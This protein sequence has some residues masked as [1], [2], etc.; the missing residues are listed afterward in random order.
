MSMYRI[1]RRKSV[2]ILSLWVSVFG[3]G[4]S[5]SRNYEEFAVLRFLNG[6][7]C[8]ALMQALA[9]WGWYLLFK[10]I[11]FQ[12]LS[13][14]KLTFLKTIGVEAIASNV[15]VKFIFV[16]YCF[17]SLGNLL[18]GLLAYLVRDWVTLQLYL[19]S[20]MTV[21]VTYFL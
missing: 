6:M 2:L 10:V 18:T 12:P 20:P 9:I 8:I 21:T 19:F 4:L 7:G 17:Q 11:P 3:I 1:G 15:R 16:I 14:Y 5:F 13:M